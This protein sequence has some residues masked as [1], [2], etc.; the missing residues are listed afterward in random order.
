MA[1]TQDARQVLSHLLSKL[2]EPDSR[3][4]ARYGPWIQK[5]GKPELEDSIFSRLRP[6]VLQFLQL[7][8]SESVTA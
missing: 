3:L 6:E 8:S 4:H 1:A 5:H 2:Q 7:G